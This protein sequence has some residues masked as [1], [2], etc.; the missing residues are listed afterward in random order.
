MR[1]V[2][3]EAGG[4]TYVGRRQ[5]GMRCVGEEAG[6]DEVCRGGGRWG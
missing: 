6:G 3:E 4:M 5:V 2:G 1:C